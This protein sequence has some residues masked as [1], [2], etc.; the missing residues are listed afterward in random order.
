MQ[1]PAKYVLPLRPFPPGVVEDSSKI[2]LKIWTFCAIL[3][4]A[5]HDLVTHQSVKI[6]EHISRVLCK[7]VK[8]S[9]QAVLLG[10]DNMKVVYVTKRFDATQVA[11]VMLKCFSTC[12]FKYMCDINIPC[13]S[14]I[15]YLI[16]DSIKENHKDIIPPVLQ[17]C[18]TYIRERG[19]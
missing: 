7:L 5:R 6:E 15:N 12:S 11:S 3:V 8:K 9:V 14:K 10:T 4:P 1:F 18:C 16:I 13:S 17:Q 19:K 2:S